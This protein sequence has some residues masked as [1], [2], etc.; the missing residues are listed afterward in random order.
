MTD[1]QQPTD[2]G[3]DANASRDLAWKRIEKKR[4]LVGGIVA[5][6][7]INAFLIGVWAMTGAGYF[8]PGLGA[9][10]M[11]RGDG[12]RHVGRLPAPSHRGRDRR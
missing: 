11:G 9:G 12:A 10:R 4:N 8:W 1:L 6:V 7:V 3:M 5:Y 2:R